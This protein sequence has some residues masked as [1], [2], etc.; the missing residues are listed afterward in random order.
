MIVDMMYSFLLPAKVYK[1][2]KPF[3]TP[4]QICE[5]CSDESERHCKYV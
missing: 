5:T 3:G 4:L 2:A 1:V